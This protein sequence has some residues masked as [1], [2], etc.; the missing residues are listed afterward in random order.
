M[1]AESYSVREA[2]AWG[3][4]AAAVLT[5]LTL[6]ALC[7]NN[8][9]GGGKK[10]RKNTQF[11]LS[12]SL[13]L[14]QTNLIK[15]SSTLGQ[16]TP[17]PCLGLGSSLRPWVQE[18][19]SLNLTV[20]SLLAGLL[21][22]ASNLHPT[23]LTLLPPFSPNSEPTWRCP[24]LFLPAASNLTILLPGVRDFQGDSTPL[25]PPHKWIL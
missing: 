5:A 9:A 20:W 10:R 14:P 6:S 17:S 1:P 21:S 16:T 18:K 22:Q 12:L 19:P 24:S 8:K 2:S 7:W 13:S 25:P 23:F 4:L 15:R 11:S 3:S